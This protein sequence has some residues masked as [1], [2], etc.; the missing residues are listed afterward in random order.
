MRP[1]FRNVGLLV[2]LFAGGMTIV[3]AIAWWTQPPN[4]PV[5]MPFVIAIFALFTLLGVY[6]LSLR[7]R[8][9]LFVGKSV[10][11]QTGVFRDDEVD[12]HT[13]DELKWRCFPQGG[14]VVMSGRTDPFKIELGNFEH[15]DRQRVIAFLQD[16]IPECQQTGRQQFDTRFSDTP[17]KKGQANRIY[18]LLVLVFALHAA[19]FGVMW[20]SGAGIQY[21]AFSGI[22]AIMV[23]YMVMRRY[24][25]QTQLGHVVGEPSDA[26]KSRSRAL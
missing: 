20:I 26:P 25:K 21:L 3:S 22:N 6:L 8:Y 12:L 14:S 1:Y 24:R 9:R 4:D 19:V 18:F 10:I 23:V 11:R 13:V 2:I 15:A 5:K 7:A 16:S 17:E